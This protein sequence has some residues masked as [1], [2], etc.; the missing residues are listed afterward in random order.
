[1]TYS[2]MQLLLQVSN[3]S[4][5]AAICHW[6]LPL[7]DSR[8]RQPISTGLLHQLVQPATTAHLPPWEESQHAHIAER[9]LQYVQ[10]K[11]VTADDDSVT[12]ILVEGPEEEVMRLRKEFDLMEKGKELV[13]GLL[14]Q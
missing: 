8:M 2:C 11:M 12:D 6:Q 14:E 10:V 1:M 9:T 3:A 5:G 13:K 4:P 7:T